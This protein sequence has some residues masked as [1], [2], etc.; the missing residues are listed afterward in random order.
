M[1]NAFMCPSL[2]LAAFLQTHTTKPVA[3][4][5]TAM[6]AVHKNF[7]RKHLAQKAGKQDIFS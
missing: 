5:T 6:G 3:A 1:T 7:Y 2:A 4:R